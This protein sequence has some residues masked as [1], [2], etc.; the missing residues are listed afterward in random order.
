[1]RSVPTGTAGSLV[2]GVNYT[3]TGDG[4]RTIVLLHGFADNA[5]T[6]NRVVPPL[7]VNHR[8]IAI[9]L[10]GFGS[11][12]RA[13]T[14]PLLPGYV[15]LVRIVLD[16]EGVDGS[17]ALM[18]NSMGAVVSLLF[19]ARHPHRTDRVVLI[20]MPALHSVP[21][22]WR[23]AMSRPAEL[24]L[25]TGLRAL[26]NGTAQYG[27]GLLYTH[28]AAWRPGQLDPAV[29]QTFAAHYAGRDRLPGI[30]PLGRLL[31][32][33]IRTAQLP[34]VLATLSVPALVVFGARD[35]LTPARVVKRLA[36]PGGAVV[37]P[38]CG[39]CPQVERPAELLS[40]VL[41]FLQVTGRPADARARTA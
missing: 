28:F 9:D 37:L 26:P 12:T 11:S 31:L 1:M 17:V 36:E 7:A 32:A 19:A 14:R 5:A 30:L 24:A 22:L 27:L 2:D 33:E 25:R 39:H 35:L 13:W 8:V 34:S 18:G 6:W 40:E 15:D 38:G 4:E 10:P 3:V 20:D 41:P 29:R 16:A 23:V 21:R